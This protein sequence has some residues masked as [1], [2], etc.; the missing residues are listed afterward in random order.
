MSASPISRVHD[1][2]KCEEL[3]LLSLIILFTEGCCLSDIAVVDSKWWGLHSGV[4]SL[5][6]TFGASRHEVVCYS[7][8]IKIK[9]LKREP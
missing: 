9:K 5:S 7:H 3:R 6:I 4:G 8:L 2:D 1:Q